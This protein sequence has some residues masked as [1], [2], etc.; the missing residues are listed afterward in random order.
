M[1]DKLVI[2]VPSIARLM[3]NFGDIALIFKKLFETVLGFTC[4]HNMFKSLGY[5]CR[6][7][8]KCSYVATLEQE[9][10]LKVIW[11]KNYSLAAILWG[12]EYVCII[13]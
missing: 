6:T 7:S 3:G 10:L 2:S 8:L 5:M 1:Y 13:Y 11:S 9:K 12:L 4:G